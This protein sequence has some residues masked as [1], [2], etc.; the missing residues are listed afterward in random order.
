MSLV[1]LAEAIRKEL[2][3][4]GLPTVLEMAVVSNSGRV[5][6]SDLSKL[7]MTKVSPFY[8]SLQLMGL[9][10]NMSLALD[11]TKTIVA[12]RVSNGAVLIVITD[13][14][15]GIILT[16][17][18]GVGDKFGRLLDELVA[19][20]ESKIGESLPSRAPVVEAQPASSAPTPSPLQVKTK[21]KEISARPAEIPKVVAPPRPTSPS[22]SIE[23]VIVPFLNDIKLLEKCPEKERKFLELFDGTLSL[24]EIS[25]RLGVP[26][27]DALQI[28][29]KYKNVGKV[30][31]KEIIRG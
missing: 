6:Y 17:M 1:T 28:A 29:N 12:S 21:E 27:F 20:E 7:A 22:K 18:G 25:Q 26:F 24:R 8:D 11:S 19:I 15:V 9:G 14:K 3:S 4:L 13:K 23:R 16:K 10:D 5:L 30:D 2:S 31:M